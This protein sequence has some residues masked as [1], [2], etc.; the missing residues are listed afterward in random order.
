MPRKFESAIFL[1]DN[2]LFGLVA[3][4]ADE[5]LALFGVRYLH[6]LEVVIGNVS[7]VGID[8]FYIDCSCVFTAAETEF[9]TV[10]CCFRRTFF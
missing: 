3:F 1:L 9:I 5:D 10:D 2:Y 6:T 7:L 8:A 4:D